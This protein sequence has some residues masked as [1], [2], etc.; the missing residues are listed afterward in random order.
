MFSVGLFYVSLGV[1]LALFGVRFLENEELGEGRK[2][3]SRTRKGI[4]AFAM[5]AYSFSCTHMSFSAL[6][7]FALQVYRALQYYSAIFIAKIA[8]VLES[9]ARTMAHRSY[10]NR[11][12]TQHYLDTEKTD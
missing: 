11:Q 12:K 3:F 1:L 6:S 5:R 4:D 7:A 8:H 10:K 9:R 2:Y